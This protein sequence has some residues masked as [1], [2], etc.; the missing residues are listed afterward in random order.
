MLKLPKNAADLTESVIDT[1]RANVLR[2]AAEHGLALDRRAVEHLRFEQ[3]SGLGDAARQS[4][5]AFV[6]SARALG[7]GIE[8]GGEREPETT[9]TGET[10]AT[11]ASRRR[12]RPPG[13]ARRDGRENAGPILPGSA[14]EPETE[15]PEPQPSEGDAQRPRPR[16]TFSE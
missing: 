14:D 8:Q 16:A 10:P 15:Q 9:G 6:N 13:S 12:G 4:E 7:L 11:P 1:K 3:I 5:A 2:F